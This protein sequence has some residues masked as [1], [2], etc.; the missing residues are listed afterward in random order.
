[1]PRQNKEEAVIKLEE[2]FSG[3]TSVVFTDYRGMPVSEMTQ[4]RRKLRERGIQYHVVK[5]TLALIAAERTGKPG[6]EKIFQGPTAL[7]Y[8]SGEDNIVAKALSDYLGSTKT[9]LSIK[10][11]LLGQRVLRREEVF[12]L[13]RLPSRLEM[14]AKLVGQIKAP[15]AS[16]PFVLG[17][18]L[19]KLIGVLEARKA[20]LN[21]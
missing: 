19:R 4:L 2:V 5:N 12:E 15:L 18:N 20:Q 1:M 16:L 13:A 11:G 3:S 14:V 21:S 17:A 9:P 10:G 6:L 7:V 8:G